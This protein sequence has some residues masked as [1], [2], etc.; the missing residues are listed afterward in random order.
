MEQT[1]DTHRAYDFTIKY[2]G[3]AF[4][5]LKQ[6]LIDNCKKWCFQ[7]E[8]DDETDPSHYRGRCSLKI[9]KSLNQ[10]NGENPYDKNMMVKGCD[11]SITSGENKRANFYITKI[12]TYVDGPWQD[13]D[14]VDFIPDHVLGIREW[15]PFQKT[16]LEEYMLSEQQKHGPAIAIA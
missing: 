4:V 1:E 15:Y 2:G 16:I 3:I 6:W 7:E 13:T 9:K 5:E 14:P 11:W 10:M 8:K 12:K